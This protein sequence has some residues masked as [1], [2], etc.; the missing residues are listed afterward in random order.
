MRGELEVKAYS[1][2]GGGEKFRVGSDTDGAR[3]KLE[4]SCA[5]RVDDF[6]SNIGLAEI[7]AANL[8]LRVKCRHS[9][10]VESC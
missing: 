10:G 5:V 8:I 2:C 4:G 9:G 3:V 1:V 7:A 6:E